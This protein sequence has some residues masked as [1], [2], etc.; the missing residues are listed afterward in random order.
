MKNKG[1]EFAS[2]LMLLLSTLNIEGISNRAIEMALL[3]IYIS[4]LYTNFVPME[5][6]LEYIESAYEESVE[7][8]KKDPIRVGL[9]NLLAKNL[10]FNTPEEAEA[11][12]RKKVEDFNIN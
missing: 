6:V 12:L 4:K 10:G 9:R 8:F 11:D 1:K 3:N 7:K 5:T 2:E